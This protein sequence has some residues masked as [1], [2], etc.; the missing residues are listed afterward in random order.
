MGLIMNEDDF[1]IPRNLDAPP[2]LWMWEA[3]S[4]V[5]VVVCVMLGGLL[6]MLL[7]G[8]LLAVLLGRGYQHLKAEGGRGL[9]MKTMFWYTPSVYWLSNRIPSHIREYIGG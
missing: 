8:I 4:A 5:L 3:D 6:N 2:L 1:W 9:I 7:V